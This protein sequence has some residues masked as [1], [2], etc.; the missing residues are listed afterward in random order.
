[1][2]ARLLTQN[3][4]LC[5]GVKPGKRGDESGQKRL[6]QTASAGRGGAFWLAKWRKETESMSGSEAPPG[7][8][9]RRVRRAENAQGR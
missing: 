7:D 1:M 3:T 8:L 6:M 4:P 2:I 5:G 9:K